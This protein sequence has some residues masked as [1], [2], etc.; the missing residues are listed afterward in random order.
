MPHISASFVPGRKPLFKESLRDLDD[1]I[2]KRNADAVAALRTA[3]LCERGMDA[4]QAAPVLPVGYVISAS[5]NAIGDRRRHADD[6]NFAQSFDAEGMAAVRFLL[7]G[8]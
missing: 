4:A 5:T 8:V 7:R 2:G 3:D 1:E 6:A